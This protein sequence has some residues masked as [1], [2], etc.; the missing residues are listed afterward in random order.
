MSERAVPRHVG[1]IPDGNRR[2]ARERGV[3][4]EA[5]YWQSMLV[6]SR[7]LVHLYTVGV[8]AIS[9]FMVSKDNLS[10]SREDLE[11][12]LRAEARCLRELLPEILQEHS[13]KSRVVGRIDLLPGHAGKAVQYLTSASVEVPAWRRLYLCVAYDVEDEL[14]S[15]RSAGDAHARIMD[16]LLVPEP[17][18]FVIRTGGDQ[19]LSGFLPIQCMYAELYFA[20]FMFPEL[21][22]E[23]LV[24]ALKDF[25]HRNRRFGR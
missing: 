2:W 9:V 15:L 18:D 24:I 23:K 6:L 5:A 7:A 14:A 22:E 10:R 13:V 3:E 25:E 1:L 11:A 20:P 12:V 21:D 17:I 16:E 19:R 8:E 4:L